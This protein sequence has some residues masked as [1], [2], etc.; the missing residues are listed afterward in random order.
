M[1]RERVVAGSS[2]WDRLRARRWFRTAAAGALPVGWVVVFLLVPYGLL[3]V[4]SLWRLTD[5]QEI[6]RWPLTLAN[7][8]PAWYAVSRGPIEVGM[9]PTLYA[10]CATP[11]M[12]SGA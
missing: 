7:Y 2:R 6:V 1:P 3:L 5:T 10:R 11:A 8:Q 4:Q 9:S 12:M